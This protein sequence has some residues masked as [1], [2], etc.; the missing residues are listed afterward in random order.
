MISKLFLFVSWFSNKSF[1]FWLVGVLVS[2]LVSSSPSMASGI[3]RRARRAGESGTGCAVSYVGMEMHSEVLMEPSGW[4]GQ[5]L[6][7]REDARLLGALRAHTCPGPA[8]LFSVL[9]SLLP[10]LPWAEC[11]VQETFDCCL[12]SKVWPDWFPPSKT[13][14]FQKLCPYIANY[15]LANWQT[16]K[17]HPALQPWTALW[18]CSAQPSKVNLLCLL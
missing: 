15:E 2:V 3:Y 1:F 14:L 12:L 5:S 7:A 8:G 18:T 16:I 10:N 11:C 13:A 17:K 9:L 6:W 4:Q